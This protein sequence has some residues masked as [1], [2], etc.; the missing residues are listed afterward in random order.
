MAL[1]TNVKDLV[2]SSFSCLQNLIDEELSVT[3][4][5]RSCL[6][7]GISD[8][9]ESSYQVYNHIYFN[10]SN[11]EF[12]KNLYLKS[13]PTEIRICNRKFVIGGLSSFKS[14][15]YIAYC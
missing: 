6:D 14:N 13:V 7:N 5:C 12:T 9:A 4:N 8:K 3:L 1:T 15:H 2:K 10:I 11:D